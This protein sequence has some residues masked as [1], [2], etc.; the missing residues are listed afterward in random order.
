MK[1]YLKLYC[2]FESIL[3]RLIYGSRLIFVISSWWWILYKV[4]CCLIQLLLSNC[5]LQSLCNIY[6]SQ[7][8]QGETSR[9]LMNRTG[10]MFSLIFVVFQDLSVQES[11][12]Q[13]AG[14][15]AVTLKE[16]IIMMLVLLL[17]LW[18][19]ILFYLRLV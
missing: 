4:Q 7:K 3:V 16:I 11:I 2:W 12:S 19:C 8:L 1:S 14:M 10:W 9:R 17:W 15:P 6:S 13:T 18:S 5:E